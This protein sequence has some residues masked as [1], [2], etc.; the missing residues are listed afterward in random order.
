MKT[1][2]N[3]DGRRV[4]LVHWKN[5]TSQPFE[6]YSN[7]KNFSLAHPRYPY[8]TL[9]NYLSKKK[10]PFETDEIR[11]ERKQIITK[12]GQVSKPNLPKRL[13]WEFKYDE[14]DWHRDSGTVIERVAERG[15]PEEWQEMIQFY[16]EKKVKTTL[17]NKTTYLTDRAIKKV[18]SFFKLKPED[19]K[20]Y[21]KKQSRPQ[22]WI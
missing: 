17:K 12:P 3:F 2:S 22:L 11:I 13:F 15:S 16:G 1:T 9:S 21:I 7:L 14:M 8:N 5:D 4:V 19:L 18:C 20:C 10:M 6:V